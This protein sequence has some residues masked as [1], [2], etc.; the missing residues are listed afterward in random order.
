MQSDA[1]FNGI[2]KIR[3]DVSGSMNMDALDYAYH[4]DF[5]TDWDFGFYLDTMKKRKLT[6]K[7]LTKRKQINEKVLR[8]F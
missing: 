7:Q 4:M 5:I 8:R 1:I 6:E 2:K 3:K